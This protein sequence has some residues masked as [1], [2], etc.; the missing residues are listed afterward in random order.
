MRTILIV[1]IT[2]LFW[3]I[4]IYIHREYGDQIKYVIEHAEEISESIEDK[5]EAVEKSIEK[6]VKQTKPTSVAVTPKQKTTPVAKQQKVEQKIAEQ[7]KAPAKSYGELICG[8]WD[9]I[10]GNI[11]PLEI[12]KYGTIVRWYI[13]GDYKSEWNR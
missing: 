5:A 9:P 6:A 2:S 3:A 10:E 13:S 7:P 4:G 8:Y 12:S 11:R 1:L